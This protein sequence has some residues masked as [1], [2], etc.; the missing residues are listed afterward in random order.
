MND[1]NRPA[2]CHT[3]SIDQVLKSLDSSL[4]GLTTEDLQARRAQYGKNT[5][6]R[7]RPNSLLR[8]FLHQFTSPLI[9]VLLLAA[10][11]SAVI[12]EW[13][14][15]GFIAG[16]LLVNAAIG[17]FQEYSAQQA[18]DALN[19][20]V[21]TV[22]KVIRSGQTSEVDASEL[23]P[24]DIVLLESGDRVPAD[25]RLSTA[26]DLTV[27]ES[28]LTGES[29]TVLKD[30]ESVVSV[31]SVLGDRENMAFAGTMITRGR[32]VGVVVTT[33]L[34]T[35]LGKIAAD[36]QTTPV[37]KAPLLVR[38]ER[39]THRVAMLVGIAALI[40][41]AI[42]LSR[43]MPMEDV[44]LLA[45]ALAVSTVPEGLPVALTVALSIGMQ[46]MARRNVIV[47]RLIA[48]ESLGSCT[49][50]ATDKTGTLTENRLTV[51][52]IVLPDNVQWDVQGDFLDTSQQTVNTENPVLQKFCQTAVL[53]NEAFLGREND[54]WTYHGDA[55][56]VAL[57]I[58]AQKAG[59]VRKETLKAQ[60]EL[61][62][63][64][65][66]SENRF[67]ASLNRAGS[68]SI[69]HLKGALDT[70]L[71]M[72]DFMLED[73]R[74]VALNAALLRSQSYQLA[75]Q[76]FRVIALASG[77]KVDQPGSESSSR[78][79]DKGSLK[80]MTLL[81]LLGLIDPLRAESQSAISAC[82]EAGIDVV[83]VTG[84]DP[85]TAEAISNELGLL[86]DNATVVSGKQL[87]Q[88]NDEKAFDALTENVPV[89][90]RVEPHHKLEIVNSLQRR[91]HFVAV[92]GDGANDAPALR[93]AQVGVA[94]GRS[95]T[96]VARETAEMIITD[97]NF[98]SIVAGIEEG[99][100]A[101][102]N[103]RKVIF[104]LISTGAAELVLFSLALLF[105]MPLPL[106]PVQ[107]LWL[108]LVTNGIQDVALAFEPGEGNELRQRPRSPKETIFNR[109]MVER[110]IWS[111]LTMGI[112]AFVVFQYLLNLGMM[113]DD[114][115]NS[116]LLLMVLFENVHV[117]NS[118]S[119]RLSAFRHNPLRNPL[120][121]FGTMAAQLIHIGAM[122]TP[123]IRDVL[124]IQPIGFDHWVTLLVFALSVL[125]VME[126][127]KHFLA[128][129]MES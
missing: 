92:S 61:A 21:S 65:Y 78:K 84:D 74:R 119:E 47:R 115:R 27:D 107:L 39:F 9:Y 49:C 121:L 100:I 75:R 26:H 29:V 48:V 89:F 112:V 44:F 24:G 12:Q 98:A 77:S 31:D 111:A 35:E 83:M 85:V 41:A 20:L 109:L 102:A 123:W 11:V 1:I 124:H 23:V 95:G 114:A 5:L 7:A 101:Y 30:A 55:V 36:V 105:A 63:I 93:A 43:G 17:T 8:V 51:K 53:A 25:L 45:V 87:K 22:C 32:A 96:D 76:G 118:R 86:D 72:C 19:Q 66:E 56:D 103:V 117:F 64:P 59:L 4:S 80:G 54:E 14:D 79:I 73:G 67:S 15:A 40:M 3:L 91:G 6:P 88:A 108:N 50:I 125:V 129:K 16:V 82:R 52:R 122:Y 81:G 10:V 127:H 113:I 62:V 94:M 58:M 120:L 71:P 104:L 90:A 46:R 13:S 38:M 2:S 128:R 116:T 37:T 34:N 97:D 18:A 57:L 68:E 110:V 106:L 60:P 33:G 69:L 99:R 70:L 42:A 126:I 28:L